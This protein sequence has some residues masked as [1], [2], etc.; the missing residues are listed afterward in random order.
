MSTAAIRVGVVGTRFGA[1]VHV[2]AFRRDRRCVVAAVA[3]R[4]AKRAEA[5]AAAL[6][7]PAFHADWRGLVADPSIDAVS[8]AV[9]PADQPAVIVAAVGNG[10]HVFCEKP[11]AASLHDAERALE[12]A[13]RARIVHAVDF[14]FP[15]IPAWQR[16]RD[17]LRRGAIG[18]PR[19]FSY[20]WRV[21]TFA[22]RT[23]AD[24]WKNRLGEGGGAVGNFLPHVI[25]NVEWLLGPLVR[26]ESTFPHEDPIS[27]CDCVAEVAGGIEG[28]VAIETDARVHAGHRLQIVGDA[29]TL[30]LSNTTS[31]YAHG[32]ELRV[33]SGGNEEL[34]ASDIGPV[35]GDGRIGAVAAIARRFVDGILEGRTATPNLEDGVHVQ[36][37]LGRITHAIPQ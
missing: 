9:P 31:D 13:R 23:R 30:M 24:S 10:K 35:D 6:E 27:F 12:A 14:I 7:V 36:R 19:R 20:A 18:A 25:F 34:V 21:Q 2:P 28:S 15:E 33:T 5:A 16:A 29:G 4:D 1:Q 26:L 22:A 32:F 11:V 8:L 3:S 17:L 37:W